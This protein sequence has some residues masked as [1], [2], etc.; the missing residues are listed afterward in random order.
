M[1]SVQLV[2]GFSAYTLWSSIKGRDPLMTIST[3]LLLLLSLL[4]VSMAA[5]GLT[6]SAAAQ[7]FVPHRAIYD[8]DV[9]DRDK[10][11]TFSQVTGRMVYEFDATCEGLIYS[12]RMLMNLVTQRGETVQS[13]AVVSFLESK[14]GRSLRFS[15]R[16][17][18]NGR[19]SAHREGSATR[20]AVGEI[21]SVT[22]SRNEGDDTD[23]VPETL[24][25]G[26][27]FPLGHSI[28]MV[29]AA[30][31][32]Q[33]VHNA[34][35]FDGDSI[36]FVDTFIGKDRG[37]HEASIPDSMKD[38]SAWMMRVSFYKPDAIDSAPYYESQMRMYANGLS[39]SFTLETD[40]LSAIARLSDV[41]LREPP[42]CE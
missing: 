41:E 20:N 18:Y 4:M 2:F 39:G 28:D 5:P 1:G 42:V 32:G 35:T 33:F 17:S 12:H 26:A 40:D 14:D 36:S 23:E 21:A 19:M 38:T 9:L 10:P 29:R 6:R 13:E 31:A 8:L 7:S 30:Q 16:E 3:R 34:K 25:K 22:Y 27:L 11:A 15:V 37:T 24:P